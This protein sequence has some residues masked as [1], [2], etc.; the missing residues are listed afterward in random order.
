[1]ATTPVLRPTAFIIYILVVLIPLLVTIFTL[2]TD[3][4]FRTTS[5]EDIRFQGASFEFYLGLYAFQ[6]RMIEDTSKGMLATI[7]PTEWTTITFDTIC[8]PDYILFGTRFNPG[9]LIDPIFCQS[10]SLWKSIALFL[11]FSILFGTIAIIFLVINGYSWYTSKDIP[12]KKQLK[13]LRREFQNRILLGI[14]GNFI[15]LLIAI[16]LIFKFRA[17]IKWPTHL[18]FEYGTFACILSC[19]LD[20]FVL[21]IFI[22]CGKHLFVFIDTPTEVLRTLSKKIFRKDTN[23]SRTASRRNTTTVGVPHPPVQNELT[24][25]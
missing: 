21:C 14:F 1:M 17:M 9:E 15:F 22:C 23:A 16:I 11:I 8:N 6:Y 13:T 3:Y 4:I 18:F 24:V 19:L 25:N 20:F 5:A 2:S 10:S 12:S 7:Y